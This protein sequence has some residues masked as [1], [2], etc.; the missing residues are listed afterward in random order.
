MSDATIPPATP[1]P[2]NFSELNAI[3]YLDESQ[4]A[5]MMRLKSKRHQGNSSGALAFSIFCR[6]DPITSGVL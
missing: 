2:N 3:G 5:A 6:A 1:K 4:V